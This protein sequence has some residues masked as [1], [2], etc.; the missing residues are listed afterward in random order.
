MRIR[1]RLLHTAFTLLLLILLAALIWPFLNVEE[2]IRRSVQQ[3]MNADFPGSVTLKK[4]ELGF[5]TV[6]LLGL[7][8]TA[9]E[10]S[11]RLRI[12]EMRLHFSPWKWISHSLNL[13]GGISSVDA[14]G[15]EISLR[16]PREAARNEERDTHLQ[17]TWD[18]LQKIPD[19]LWIERGSLSAGTIHLL[20]PDGD[21][22]WTM[23][24]LNGQIRAKRPG[25]LKARL[26][27]GPIARGE[28]SGDL[29][30][31]LDAEKRLL[32]TVLTARLG[33]I[34]LGGKSGLPDSLSLDLDSLAADLRLWSREADNG[35][36][37]EIRLQGADLK[38]RRQNLLSCDSLKFVLG[39]WRV[40]LPVLNARGLRGKWT[41]KGEIP[42]VRNPSWDLQVL[43][44]SSKGEG[45]LEDLL[46]GSKLS[47]S[48]GYRLE[49]HLSGTPSRP[50][51]RFEVAAGR[52]IRTG[53]ELDSLRFAGNWQPGRISLD[54]L[55]ARH[56]YGH[57]SG[58]GEVTFGPDG[59]YRAN[60]HL[61]GKP[62]RYPDLA[63]GSLTLKSSGTP[64]EHHLVGTWHNDAEPDK[65]VAF[66]LDYSS[67]KGTFS[68]R[69]N[70]A[71]NAA[72][73][74]LDVTG[75][76]SPP[77][78]RFAFDNPLP[79]I[80]LLVEGSP[81][82]RL[83]GLYLSGSAEGEL[84]DLKS[85]FEIYDIKRRSRF[86]FDGTVVGGGKGDLSYQ[87]D[88][89]FQQGS[90]SPLHGFVSLR[91]KDNTLTLKDLQLDD[92]IFAHGSVDFRSGQIGLTE[93]RV[94]N[95]DV[96]RGIRLFLPDFAARI[97]GYLDGRIELFGN[98]DH[99]LAS[100]N[101]YASRGYYRSQS[102]FWAVLSAGYRDNVF[103]V[104]ECNIGRSLTSLVSVTGSFRSDGTELNLRAV[105]DRADV[106]D[107]L[108][109]VGSNP[110][111]MRGP[112]FLQAELRGSRA[113]PE[114]SAQLKINRG[115]LDRLS[116]SRLEAAV[117]L[118]STTGHKLRLEDFHLVQAPD[119]AMTGSGDLP[120]AGAPLHLQFSL[121]G[122]V[123]KI[124]ALM[125][126]SIPESRGKGEVRFVLDGAGGKVRL[127]EARLRI[128]NG[129]MRFPDVVEGIEALQAD[130][131]LE[132]GKLR[133]E[134]LQGKVNSQIF[135][136]RNR[137]N[138]ATGAEEL[139]HLAFPALGL[140]LGVITLETEGRG[141]YGRIPSLMIKGSK[142]YI[143]LEGR[144]KGEKFTFA[145]PVDHPL[146]RG[147]VR[148]SRTIMTYPFPPA[149]KKPSKFVRG[150][151]KVL[152]SAEWDL[153][154]IP[155]RDNRYVRELKGTVSSPLLE[156][157]S[158]LLTTVDINL[159]INPGLSN[160]SIIGSPGQ[161]TF[162]MLG[163]LISTRGSIEYL[164]FKFRVDRFEVE[165]DEYSPLPWVEG[166]G[167]T[168]YKDSLGISRNVYLTLYVVDPITGER[169]KR[170]RWGDF[171][172]ILEDDAGS[173]QEQILAAMGYSPERIT[174]KMT[175]ISGQIVS[176][177]V[178]RR[179]IRP[180]ERELE[181]LL[182]LDYVR[183]QPTIA[184][185]LFETEILGID[186]GPSSEI[187]W[188]AY[189]LRQSRFSVGKYF[190]DDLF[191]I[192]T[193]MYESAINAQNERRFGFLHNWS[194]E[195][196]LRPI[197]PNLVLDFSYE[198][199]SLERLRDR[200]VKLRYSILF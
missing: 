44:E 181:V 125:D 171:V 137:F 192:Y 123:L 182:D 84:T 70:E 37:G 175:S 170:G 104:E 77:R 197:S 46:P 107:L 100:I 109:L 138:A 10:E 42:D 177:A 185:H 143:K 102:G 74:D 22:L 129:L 68:L 184:Q 26:G 141:I 62:P 150:V 23:N 139:Q 189:Y 163:H 9:P 98:L 103:T 191:V 81:W 58:A 162:R 33:A 96:A 89:L 73:F 176:D 160:L 94:T 99:P 40:L 118:D 121:T 93:L 83:Q 1:T 157:M 196:R 110:L 183:F 43:A 3:Q 131:R 71:Q 165:F 91:W 127:A 53:D 142:G 80:R 47:L 15:V 149:R 25:V 158:D 18:L 126:R 61:A 55:T 133:I 66:S 97:G 78:Y 59:G 145:G 147:T 115:R 200:A 24:N 50:R 88:L 13:L 82:N 132:D 193:G 90:S 29:R 154:V 114:F 95:W 168:V 72:S 17:V 39:D 161:G 20:T 187:G 111:K 75:L 136:F 92:A 172:F 152:Q 144:E 87:G 35:L 199:D 166:R 2:R 57:I 36:E 86:S 179:W 128:Q 31:L 156:G 38:Y 21:P 169:T 140:D 113:S 153:K 79:I 174:E 116:F 12:A 108:S 45:L 60:F 11:Y 14:A 119:L 27:I 164:D 117:L 63:H 130:L 159:N 198:Y 65:P 49:A 16:L 120:F 101:F 51:L 64:K 135:R 134:K 188:G 67:L 151:L 69:L 4:V 30:V 195:Y 56:R 41:I 32:E 155:E 106:A 167:Q 112:L 122:N 178:L 8:I 146:F 5:F 85:R 52:I 28:P 54:R 76:P 190:T 194:I 7:D 19:F 34:S 6:N 105:S 148:I 173:S 48:G 186:P 180:I 124:P